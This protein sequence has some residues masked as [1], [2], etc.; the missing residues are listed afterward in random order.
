[1][2]WLF[3]A[4]PLLAHL[5]TLVHSDRLAGL[6][7]TVFVAVPL[8]P[9]L[10]R[11]AAWAWLVLLSAAA[12]LYLGAIG[13]VARYFMYLPPV[14]IP[15]AVCAVFARTLRPGA[16]PLVTQ[17]AAQIRGP[18]PPELLAYTRAVTC[19]W[20][21]LLAALALSSLLLALF[22]TPELWSLV[23]NL[24]LYVLLAT[25][26]LLE[27]LYRRWRFRHLPHESFAAMVGAL[28]KLRTSA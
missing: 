24:L 17:I 20:V 18:L 8:L 1:M 3:P 14:L 4:Y 9:A 6:A 15:A 5:A 27:Y 12:L 25:V 28:F 11:R 16:T 13:G 26:F 10:R 23:S 21:A 2:S 22:A 19:F 7:L